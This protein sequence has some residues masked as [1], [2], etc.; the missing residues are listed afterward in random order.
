MG[1]TESI[2]M[3]VP[4][5]QSTCLCRR[6]EYSLNESTNQCVPGNP[7]SPL[8]TLNGEEGGRSRGERRLPAV[9][10]KEERSEEARRGRSRY[11]L[12]NGVMFE[13]SQ[14]DTPLVFAHAF[15]APAM[16]EGGA[17]D[18]I[19]QEFVGNGR[20]LRRSTAE[21]ERTVEEPTVLGFSPR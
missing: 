17:G 13:G 1:L 3:F 16:P 15:E 8:L 20:W 19:E 12:S 6:V 7:S 18:D 4:M 21:R 9:S 5:N 10:A 2:N 11:L 14:A